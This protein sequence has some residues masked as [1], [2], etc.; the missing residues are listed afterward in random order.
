MKLPIIR[1]ILV[2]IDGSKNSLR[3]L[4]YA[5]HLARQCGAIVTGINVIPFYPKSLILTPISYEKELAKKAKE[6]MAKVKVRCAQ[7]GVVFSEKITDGHKAEEIVGFAADKKFDLI[8]IGARGLGSVK[9]VFLGSVSNGVLHKSKIPVLIVKWWW[10]SI[11]SIIGA[12]RVGSAVGF[13]AASTALDDIVLVNSTKNKAIG[14]ALDITNAIPECSQISVIGT[15]DF[16]LI[17]DSKVIVITASKGKITTTRTDLLTANVPLAKEIAQKIR[18]YNDNA[19]IVI[20]TNPLDVVTYTILKETGFPRESVIGM[21]S[22]LDSS[23]FRYLLAKSL[24]TNM[25]KIEGIVMGEHGDSMVPIFSTA[26]CDEK[27][28][29]N[30]L[31]QSE[32]ARITEELR[33]YWKLLKRFKEASVFGAAKNA[34]DIVKAIVHDE[35]L[36]TPASILLEGEYGLSD[37]CLGISVTIG[38]N[39]V[40]KINK[41]DLDRSELKSLNDSAQ[42][43]RNNLMKIKN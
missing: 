40:A 34:L 39:G 26:K 43:I 14:E 15:D 13:L 8:V 5:I 4:D 9:E 28:I 36:K 21:G 29:L 7:N 10:N 24:N 33:N 1:K 35:K 22:S 37:I 27:P 12:G 32:T 42:I 25:S 20:V 11:I 16:E 41:L 3:G 23:R 30:M 2:P 17:K 31:E 6:L 18:K 19:K 38:K